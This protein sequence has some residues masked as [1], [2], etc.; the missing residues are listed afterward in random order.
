MLSQI[1]ARSTTSGMSTNS[2]S[3]AYIP[4][5]KKGKKDKGET[6]YRYGWIH[7]LIYRTEVY[8]VNGVESQSFNRRTY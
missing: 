5:K 1:S 4:R 7:R 8:R 3:I 2:N 6:I